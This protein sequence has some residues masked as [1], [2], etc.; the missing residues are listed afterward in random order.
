MRVRMIAN[1]YSKRVR[2]ATI[3]APVECLILTQLRNDAWES[4]QRRNRCSQPLNLQNQNVVF[5]AK[6]LCG[7]R[8]MVGGGLIA[9]HL[10]DSIESEQLALR[11]LCFD[12]SIR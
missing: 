12:D 9:Q 5:L 8:E 7:G 10:V 4:R 11:I 2:S 3:L 1:R 6:F